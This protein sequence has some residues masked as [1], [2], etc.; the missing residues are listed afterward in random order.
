MTGNDLRQEFLHFF[1][2]KNS[3]VVP[4]SSL[5]P[6]DPT[7]LLT[8]AG[9]QPLVPYFKG[10]ETPPST[11]LASCQKCCRADD[12]EQ[13]GVTWRHASFFE[14][15]GNFSFGD[16]FKR[17][18]I[19][20]GW[21]FLTKRMNIDPKLLWVSVYHE[22]EEAPEIWKKDVGLSDDRILRFGKKD[23]WW[24]PVGKAGPCGPDSEI[25]FDRGPQFDTGDPEMDR[26]GGDGDRYGEIWNLVFQQYNQQENGEL[27]S[28]PAPGIDT[29]MGLERTAA[30]LQGVSTIHHTDLFAPIINA[31]K[32]AQSET[33][34]Y[35]LSRPELNPEDPTTKPL[36]VIADHIRAAVFMAADGIIPGNNGRDYMLRRFIRRAF[37]MGRQLGYN[38]PFLHRIAPVIAQGYGDS[39]PE[40]RDRLDIISGLIAREE[41]RFQTTLDAGMNRLEN[42]LEDAK[43]KDIRVLD[44]EEVFRLYETYGFPRE[45]TQEVA[46]ESGLEIDEAGYRA[47]QER[48]SKTSGSGVG[49]YESRRFANHETEFVG[50][51]LTE[52]DAKVVEAVVTITDASKVTAILLDKTPFYAESGGQIGDQGEIVGED[53]HAFVL[54]TKREG[55]AFVHIVNVV[56]G[57]DKCLR[58][59]L[60]FKVRAVVNDT[61]RRAI[62][63]AH[64]STHLLHAA[65]RQHLGKHVEQRGSLVEPD[66]LR[67]DFVHFSPITSEEIAQIEDTVNQKILE[68]TPVEIKNSTL[69]EARAAG[70]MALFGEKYGDV[71]RTVRMGDFSLELCGGTHLPVTSAAGFLRIVSEGGVG[72]NLRRIEALTGEAALRYDREQENRLREASRVLG[73]QPENVSG[74]AEKLRARVRELEKQLQAA[75][76]KMAAASTDDLLANAQEIGGVKLAVGRAPQGLNANALRELADRLSDKLNGVVVLAAEDGGKVLWAVKAAKSAVESGAHAGNLVRELAK[77]TGG[78][79]GGR[80]DFAQAGGKDT[81]K[82]DEALNAVSEIFSQQLTK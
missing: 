26:P 48:H 81:S 5:V 64:S 46:Q 12:I 73:T 78:G 9:M 44:G 54:D 22:D 25:F 32:N 21:E 30:I 67:F 34:E 33:I 39:Y 55:K 16:Y 74:A 76:Q 36:R 20:W 41:E 49:E 58:N 72:A 80:P 2:Q 52:C 1:E 57:E 61:R 77:I 24:G 31:I 15:L 8:S 62:E 3:L 79:G 60:D 69:D 59:K 65:L 37:L 11:R 75:Q 27:L 47:A 6:T 56:K 13:V 14:M 4:S 23:N 70:A 40:V 35:S 19:I 68:S 51:E 18:A 28:L 42:L 63:R 45:V 29:G 71:V 82:I 50:Y 17:E 38:E 7:T 53:F 10:E 66:R 43:K